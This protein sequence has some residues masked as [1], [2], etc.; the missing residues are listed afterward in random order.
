L[1]SILY[2]KLFSSISSFHG[3]CPTICAFDV[4]T[5]TVGL[6]TS[7]AL[8]ATPMARAQHK[9]ARGAQPSIADEVAVAVSDRRVIEFCVGSSRTSRE[10]VT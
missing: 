1:A 5:V 4:E 8:T 10:A 7:I 6:G 9:G 3:V 2:R